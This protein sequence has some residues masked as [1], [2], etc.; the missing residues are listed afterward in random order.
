MV[1]DSLPPPPPPRQR[2]SIAARLALIAFGTAFVTSFLPWVR[3]LFVSV[4]GTDGDGVI[5]LVAAG[6]GFGSVVL[7]ERSTRKVLAI[8]IMIVASGALTSL[9]FVYNLADVSRTA[10]ESANDIFDLQ[11]SPQFGL[12]VGAVVAPIA[13]FCGVLR[14]TQHLSGRHR[15]EHE[16]SAPS[17]WTPSDLV[18]GSIAVAT[19]PIAVAPTLWA[20]SA[21]LVIALAAVLWFA[22]RQ[23][24]IRRTCVVMSVVGIV[25]A[26]GGT[27]YGIV[28]TDNSTSFS[29]AMTDS[30]QGFP[31]DD[32]EACSNVYTSGTSTNDIDEPI[33]CLDSGVET[34]VFPVTWE[35]EDGRTLVSTEY[36]WGYV[37]DTWSTVGEAPYD[38][39]Q[40]SA[41]ELCTEIFSDGTS[42]DATWVDDVI[43][44]FDA[45]G[46]IDYVLTTRW[47]CFDSEQVQ[48]SNR[49][50]W[51]YLGKTWVG[52]QDTPFC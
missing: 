48:L 51:G 49:Y 14:L 2:L 36:G 21:V 38:R 23:S 16:L 3:V 26:A 25:I 11:V 6:I 15:S 4:N 31:V 5:S 39:C 30:L 47:D 19:I 20:F 12:V 1:D 42:T 9:V 29:S 43:E 35:C 45:E 40:S 8:H 24:R 22:A 44:C 7:S 50:G 34:Y 13:L 17:P 33:L 18:V 52:G 28:D 46:E 41:Q 27:V 32:L 37:D 10:G